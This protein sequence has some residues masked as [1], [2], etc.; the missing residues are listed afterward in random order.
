[1]IR[2]ISKPVEDEGVDEVF[3]ADPRDGT[4]F[5]VRNGVAVAVGI[6]AKD[7]YR[8]TGIAMVVTNT[9]AILRAPRWRGSQVPLLYSPGH[10]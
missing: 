7:G 4:A 1:M 3:A 5:G 9:G 2:N 8:P 10:F 6:L